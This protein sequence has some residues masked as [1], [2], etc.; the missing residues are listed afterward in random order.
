[1]DFK[2]YQARTGD[3]ALYPGVGSNYVYPTLGLA[4]EAGEIANKVK[5]ISRDQNGVV[6]PEVRTMIKAELG[7]VLWYVARLAEEFGL[8]L[9]EIAEENIAKLAS[10]KE[11]GTLHGDGDTR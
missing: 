11:R 3:T 7:D 1:M 5:K 9:Q 8:S 2:E 4:G 6:T 10:R